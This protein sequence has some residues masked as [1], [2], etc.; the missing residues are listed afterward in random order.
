MNSNADKSKLY[1][2]AKC[3]T[4]I[5]VVAAHVTT[6]YTANGAIPVANESGVLAAL[7]SY[8][9]AFH[10]PLFVLLSGCV[11][12]YCIEQG[13]YSNLPAFVLNKGKKL[14]LPYL[15]FGILYV[16]PV[17]CALGLT[18]SFGRY[19]LRG[20]LL[21][22]NSR[23]LWYILALFWIFLIYILMRPLFRKGPVGW[24]I[25]GCICLL[26]FFIRGKIPGVLQL[27][28]ACNYQLFFFLGIL[29]NRFY[30]GIARVFKTGWKLGWILPIALLL[31]FFYNPN[32]ITSYLYKVIGTVMILLFCWIM[33]RWFPNLLAAPLVSVVKQNSFGIYL[34][35]PMIIY[36]LFYLLGQYNIHPIILSVLIFV[37]ATV[38][39]ICATKVLRKIKLHWI[40]G[41]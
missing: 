26:L 19:V 36:V 22:Y 30:S 37:V 6:M 5:L 4:T 8:I 25:A 7:T 1:D 17:M 16:A 31:M 24:I 18:D 20:I 15:V 40:I 28:A 10:M 11:F 32:T 41:E 14:V 21:S 38:L 34:F 39:S 9:Y 2:L 13:K 23:H 27:S 12:G 29:F 33:L 3:V 35:H